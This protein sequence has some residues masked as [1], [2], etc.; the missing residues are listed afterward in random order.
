MALEV[1]EVLE[2]LGMKPDEVKTIEDLKTGFDKEFIRTSLINED[3]EPVKKITGKVLGI[4]ESK[5]KALAKNVEID[6][7]SD[8][9]KKK[10]KITDKIEYVF[11]KY[12]EKKTSIIKD[13]EA[14]AGQGNDEKVKEW[15]QKYEKL[16]TKYGE[17]DSLLK[18][19]SKEYEDFKQNSEKNLRSVKIGVHKK[20]L[21]GKAKFIPEIN[22]YA[23]KGF[24]NEF[25]EKYKI[26]LDEN[27]KVIIMD[28]EGK[29]IPNPKVTGSF[30]EPE[31]LLTEE[32]VKAKMFELNPQA[33]RQQTTSRQQTTTATRTN[34]SQAVRKV[35]ERL[36]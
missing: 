21:F 14:K 5:I 27:E 31:D 10:E 1:K 33:K 29:R 4:V 8:D 30:Y 3:L 24:I 7:D 12:D 36:G 32:L 17:T 20:E 35:A 9:F 18:N 22:E 6:L 34:D 15:E 23:K 11:S 2:Y 19:T 28:K 13:L 26:D 25:E 16:K